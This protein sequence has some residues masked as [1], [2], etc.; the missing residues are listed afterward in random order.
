MARVT[1]FPEETNPADDDW[2]P[3]VDT[4]AGKSKRV[5]VANLGTAI[6]G[7][8]SG[9]G[10]SGFTYVISSHA[11]PSAPE[12]GETW[13]QQN[14]GK[15]LVRVAGLWQEFSDRNALLDV[16]VP[17]DIDA[18]GTPSSST[19]LRGD[20]AW[21]TPAVSS[22]AV[23]VNITDTGELYTATNVEAALAEVK[24][25]ADTAA[26]GGIAKTGTPVADD[27][28]K[29]TNGTTVEGRSYAETRT[30]LGLARGTDTPP[31]TP[32]QYQR[33]VDSGS[34]RAFYWDGTFWVEIAGTPPVIV[35]N[36][37]ELSDFGGFVQPDQGGFGFSIDPVDGYPADALQSIGGAAASHGHRVQFTEV[38]T[39]TYTLSPVD[40]GRVLLFNVAGNAACTVTL[41]N[42]DTQSG[43][44]SGM[45]IG[46]LPYSSGAITIAPAASVNVDGTVATSFS[47]VQHGMATLT[48]MLA[49]NFWNYSGQVGA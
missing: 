46:F 18:T 17:D 1:D 36:E 10:G 45:V 21:A 2:I 13:Y 23:D 11:P 3:I 6:G 48:R 30:D 39:T 34:G 38:T 28:A 7:S 8:G 31:A 19:Y 20:G 24:A 15:S 27:F 37:F 44:Q 16:D 5:S 4:S 43:W 29:F 26:G 49:N 22:A 41:P 14:T 25:V 9:D 42:Q 35:P 33:W 40:E 47:L 32:Y 12:N